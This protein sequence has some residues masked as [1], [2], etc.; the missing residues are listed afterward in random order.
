MQLTSNV[1]SST[2]Y[3]VAVPS[4]PR[5]YPAEVIDFDVDWALRLA[6]GETI[7]NHAV[8]A[9]PSGL[10]V[11]AS[12]GASPTRTRLDISGGTEGVT[13]VL[14]I[15]ATTSLNNV[16]VQKVSVPVATL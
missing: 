3:E 7:S 2:Q 12:A 16:L 8:T 6:T 5:K 1:Y 13:H 15:T 14:T 10:T 9:A 11:A 4:F